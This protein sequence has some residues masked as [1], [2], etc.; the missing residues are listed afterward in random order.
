MMQSKH[1]MCQPIKGLGN[2]VILECNA[3]KTPYKKPAEAQN[4]R[5]GEGRNLSGSLA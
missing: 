3:V 5:R 1:A 4:D 2:D